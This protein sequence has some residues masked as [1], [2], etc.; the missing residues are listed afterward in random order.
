MAAERIAVPADVAGLDII[1]SASGGKDSTSLLLALKEA[2]IPFRA[3]FADTGWEADETYEYLD[4]LR[5]LVCPIEVVRPTRDMVASIKHRAGFPARMQRWCTRELKIEPL[6]AFHDEHIARAG[7][8]TVSA[9]GIRAEESTDRAAMPMLDDEPEWIDIVDDD[10]RPKRV[11][12]WGGWVWRP[13]LSWTIDDV[14]AIHHRHG[15]PLNP[16]YLAG[17]DRVGCYPCIF[18][19]KEEIRL[20]A[21]RS[22]ERIAL[23]E[24]LEREQTEERA[25]RNV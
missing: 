22:P 19:R 13:L 25:R 18:S 1:A 23:I 7:G 8:E 20:L 10:G 9:M 6:R 11:R 5:R 16:L 15:V 12:G 17:F 2:Q 21:Q 3:V 4:L 14:V 24:Q